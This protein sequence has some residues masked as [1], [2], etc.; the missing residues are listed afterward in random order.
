MNMLK[1]ISPV[2][3]LAALLACS[4][5]PSTTPE[6]VRPPSAGSRYERLV[7]RLEAGDLSID[8]DSLRYAYVESPRYMPYGFALDELQDSARAALEAGHN[9]QA[10]R[11]ADAMLDSSYV[12]PR[13]HLLAFAAC[14]ALGD[15]A[16]RDHHGYVLNGLL[17]SIERSGA[18]DS[19]DDPMVV[20]VLA[21]EYFYLYVHGLQ[22]VSQALTS[23]GDVACDELEVRSAD[24]DSTFH[25]YF[26]VSRLME[27]VRRQIPPDP[28][29]NDQ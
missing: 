25:L 24:S 21:E 23:C 11:L 7:A 10:L 1:P 17:E 28:E 2:P 16:R 26:D 20:V 27:A 13:A 6:A 12:Y 9:E 3:V 5:G 22:L 18:G 15:S 19:R 4:T 14:D 29:R 8:F